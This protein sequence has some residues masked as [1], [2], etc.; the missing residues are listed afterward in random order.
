MI[1][2]KRKLFFDYEKEEKWLNEMAAEGFNFVKYTFGTYH[3]EEGKKGEYYYRIQLLDQVADHQESK[4]YINFMEDNGVECVY[5][6]LRWG[7]FRKRKEE[8]TFEIYSDYESRIKHYKNIA[9][10]IGT[11]GAMNIIVGAFNM[12]LSTI[13]LYLSSVSWLTALILTPVFLTYLNKVKKL[14]KEQELYHK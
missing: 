1:I 12:T 7:Y 10:L 4:E 11:V 6:F 2:K 3:F 9:T 8:G 13:N 14:K 5:T